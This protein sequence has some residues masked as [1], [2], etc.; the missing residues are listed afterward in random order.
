MEIPV[1]YEEMVAKVDEL[2]RRM[3]L[4]A[5]VFVYLYNEL[6]DLF[7]TDEAFDSGVRNVFED[8]HD[9]F[10]IHRFRRLI[11]LPPP[12][13]SR[14][15]TKSAPI[16]LTSSYGIEGRR[17]TSYLGFFSD[18]VAVGMGLGK[19][20]LSSFADIAGTES[21]ALGEKLKEAKGFVQK[22]FL[23]TAREMGADAVIGCDIDYTM[24]ADTI[25]GVIMSGTAV[26]LTPNGTDE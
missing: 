20:F 3:D 24:F 21:S 10:D 14:T 2:E 13:E 15:P 11:D 22:K 19:A 8:S 12:G 17:I 6:K 23:R 18:E 25:L 4:P 7:D 5:D 9:E 1:T 16:L 26:K